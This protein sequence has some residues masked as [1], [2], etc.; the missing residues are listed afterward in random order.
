MCFG[1]TAQSKLTSTGF[2]SGVS[3]FSRNGQLLRWP[4]ATLFLKHLSW[5]FISSHTSSSTFHL[6]NNHLVSI[7][8]PFSPPPE[9]LPAFPQWLG[10]LCYSRLVNW[11]QLQDMMGM[12]GDYCPGL[13]ASVSWRAEAHTVRRKSKQL[14]AEVCFSCWRAL[15]AFW[16]GSPSS[17]SQIK[18][19]LISKF[20]NSLWRRWI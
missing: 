2:S 18:I 12:D 4:T 6:L 3:S 17:K 20:R 14:A 1:G 7:N 15:C 10:C 9:A 11:E 5:C 8:L 19:S 13:K 16:F